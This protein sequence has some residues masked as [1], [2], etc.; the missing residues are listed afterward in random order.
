M[1]NLIPDDLLQV[2]RILSIF[3]GLYA[4]MFGLLLATDRSELKKQK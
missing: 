3:V 1:F 4:I 2:I